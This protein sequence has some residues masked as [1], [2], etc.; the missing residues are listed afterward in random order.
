MLLISLL[1]H[2]WAF[3]WDSLQ[4]Q[5][6]LSFLSSLLSVQHHAPVKRISL[7]L[8]GEE[9]SA[10]EQVKCALLLC[11]EVFTYLLERME[12]E[13]RN[14]QSPSWVAGASG[15]DTKAAADKQN[16]HFTHVQPDRVWFAEIARILYSRSLSETWVYITN[17]LKY[18]N[19]LCIELL[20]KKWSL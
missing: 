5:T 8:W 11:C 6:R 4:S 2:H 20:I 3:S 15:E 7:T 9:S 10:S 12:L 1:Y 19:E 18:Y 14:C 16:Y 17:P 13:A